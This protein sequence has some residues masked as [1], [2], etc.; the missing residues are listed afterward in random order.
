MQRKI[1]E[2]PVQHSRATS[3]FKEQSEFPSPYLSPDLEENQDDEVDTQMQASR[4]RKQESLLQESA[5]KEEGGRERESTWGG[6]DTMKRSERD[7]ED[8]VQE[9]EN[10]G[11]N[12]EFCFWKGKFCGNGR[13]NGQEFRVRH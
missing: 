7:Q 9:V 12:E 11:E 6:D 10:R 2:F 4:S 13:R 8:G 1:H 3:R 5:M